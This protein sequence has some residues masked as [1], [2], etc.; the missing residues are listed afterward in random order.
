MEALLMFWLAM[1]LLCAGIAAGKR[2]VSAAIGF[3]I[4]G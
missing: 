2:G 1:A 4:Y 3:F